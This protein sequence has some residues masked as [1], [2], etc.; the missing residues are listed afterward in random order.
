MITEKLIFKIPYELSPIPED[1]DVIFGANYYDHWRAWDAGSLTL[2]GSLVDSAASLTGSGREMLSS[3]INRPSLITDVT[4]GKNVFSFDGVSERMS[5]PSSN[6]LYNFLHNG[7]GGVVIS[8]FRV[9]DVNPDLLYCL[10]DNNN[11]ATAS[12]GVSLLFDDRSSISRNNTYR[13][14]IVRGV[15]ASFTSLVQSANDYIET[16]KYISLVSTFDADN[17][18]L[19]DR[20]NIYVNDGLVLNNNSSS[21]A[22][23]IA[24]ASFNLT[25][26]SA[27]GGSLSAKINLAE[28][29]IA[30]TVPTPTQL[31]QIQAR[32][33]YDYGTT[34]PIT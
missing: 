4:L 24:N 34:F 15:N 25:M 19:A 30:D 2:T 17:A 1:Y 31:S 7:I 13:E 22:A 28:V 27:A 32:L 10:L 11:I 23:S 5:V 6:G 26:G 14:F 12:V 8:V 29:I 33:I 3:G 16:Q 21:G 20:S 18:T 9:E